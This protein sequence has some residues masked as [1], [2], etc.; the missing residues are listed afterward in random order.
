MLKRFGQV[1]LKPDLPRLHVEPASEEVQ[2]KMSSCCDCCPLGLWCFAFWTRHRTEQNALVEMFAGRSRRTLSFLKEIL[3]LDFAVK[4]GMPGSVVWLWVQMLLQDTLL[5][6]WS[7]L[8]SNV[9]WHISRIGRIH[10]QGLMT[11]LQASPARYKFLQS[12]V[13]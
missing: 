11:T 13:L 8:P 2:S 9:M 5:L 6:Y 1:L 12:F 10:M 3:L 4:D 7:A